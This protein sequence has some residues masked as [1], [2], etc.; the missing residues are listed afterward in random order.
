[1]QDN[2]EIATSETKPVRYTKEER[3]AREERF[4]H[5]T[6]QL[7]QST[8]VQ[9]Y[10]LADM[11]ISRLYEVAYESW[12][13]YVDKELPF[14]G[15]EKA[16]DYVSIIKAFGESD[17]LKSLMAKKSLKPLI[18]AA[19]QIN[20]QRAN[21]PITDERIQEMVDI[22]TEKLRKKNQEQKEK[23][24]L[25]EEFITTKENQVRELQQDLHSKQTEI[26]RIAESIAKANDFDLLKFK[27]LTSEKELKK[28]IWEMMGLIN[29]LTALI[30]DAPVDLRTAE[31]TGIV[32]MATA[33]FETSLR[34]IEDKW[35]TELADYTP[36]LSNRP[37]SI[38][39]NSEDLS[40]DDDTSLVP[41]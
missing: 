3:Q 15:I 23:L 34:M 30:C 9:A 2:Q 6:N 37:Q 22:Q 38:Q 31:I 25:N 12:E 11:K 36:H 5:L 1:M 39:V 33:G 7:Q 35:L 26:D 28:K 18:E 14:L 10:I 19:K 41:N 40:Q 8:Y 13:D 16:N 24:R 29:E 32:K 17:K 20:D 21:S 27:T 4:F